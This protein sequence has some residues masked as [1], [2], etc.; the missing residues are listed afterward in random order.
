MSIALSNSSRSTAR[1]SRSL[2]SS[3]RSSGRSSLHELCSR[4]STVGGFAAGSGR[5]TFITWNRGGLNR[6]YHKP[7]RERHTFNHNL[8][9]T[10]NISLSKSC[11]KKRISNTPTGRFRPR[12]PK[13]FNDNNGPCY[14]KKSVDPNNFSVEEMFSGFNVEKTLHSTPRQ[15]RAKKFNKIQEHIKNVN[16]P[17]KAKRNAFLQKS[18]EN[19]ERARLYEKHTKGRVRIERKKPSFRNCH[20]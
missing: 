2:K 19:R 5:D 11:K 12:P 7:G 13:I 8:R 9:N 17:V 4:L 15:N 1:S 18:K 10:I 20:G 14:G 16:I 3:S 6:D